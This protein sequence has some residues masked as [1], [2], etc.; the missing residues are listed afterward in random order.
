MRV[1]DIVIGAT[2][3]D[4]RV[5]GEKHLVDKTAYF[6][7]KC[8][9]CGKIW[10]VAAKHIGSIK[11]CYDCHAKSRIVDLTNMRFG[12]LVPIRFVERRNGRTLWECVCDCGNH[13]IVGYSNL[14]NGITKSCGCYDSECK[15][16]RNRDR[17]RCATSKDFS[18]FPII[19]DHPL[20]RIWSSMVTRCYNPNSNHYRNYG[21]R[22]I[23]VCDRW[24][25]ENGF[26][27]FVRDMGERPSSKHS[28]DRI[29]VNKGYEPSNC[30]WATTKEQSRN[31]QTTKYVYLNGCEIPLAELCEMFGLSYWCVSH[32]I[33]R[34]FDLDY[35][36]HHPKCD[37][38]RKE[39]ANK[40]RNYNL[41]VFIDTPIGKDKK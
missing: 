19:S 10:D 15:L 9:K 16:Q 28:I 36:V 29:N 12:K 32:K 7:C 41:Q 34:G 20:Y 8:L 25:G 22:G 23:E 39:Y 17:R 27:N 4:V 40:H 30:R 5:I 31:K 14:V 1:K 33:R 26:E 18:C 13:T 6:K 24:L 3:N 2:Y 38:R 11:S 35:I 21:G 37:F